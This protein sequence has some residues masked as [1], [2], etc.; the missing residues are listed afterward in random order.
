MII[1]GWGNAASD[2]IIDDLNAE[3][4]FEKRKD[5][6]MTLQKM[7]HD[8]V[9]VI[10]LFAQKNRLAISKKFSVETILINPGYSVSEFKAN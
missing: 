10:F 5:Y 7:I 4:D 8:D 6:Y 9:P 3:L 1:T 2:K